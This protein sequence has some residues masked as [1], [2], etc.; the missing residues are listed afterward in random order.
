MGKLDLAWLRTLESQLQYVAFGLRTSIE[1]Q[2][3]VCVTPSKYRVVVKIE[4][5]TFFHPD[6]GMLRRSRCIQI[7]FFF[8]LPR[9]LSDTDSN[10][11]THTLSSTG[12]PSRP[13]ASFSP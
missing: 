3:N 5:T 10:R 7:D 2:E 6:W 8:D 1:K 11:R 9:I 4:G 13:V 12:I